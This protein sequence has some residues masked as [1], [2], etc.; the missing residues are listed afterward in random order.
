MTQTNLDNKKVRG[1]LVAWRKTV[2]E[3]FVVFCFDESSESHHV[4]ALP[5]YDHDEVLT[6]VLIHNN[7]LMFYIVITNSQ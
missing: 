7:T 3:F 1:A 5:Q 2:F 6:L 4:T